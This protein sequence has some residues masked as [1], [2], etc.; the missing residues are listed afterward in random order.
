MWR[1]VKERNINKREIKEYLKQKRFI[2]LLFHLFSFMVD[3][4]NTKH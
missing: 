1:G 2:I 3:Y 4:T